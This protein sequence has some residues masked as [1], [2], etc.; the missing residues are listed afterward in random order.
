MPISEINRKIEVY[1]KG[2]IC[3]GDKTT[4]GGQVLSGSGKM[5]FAGIGVARLNDPVSCP[6]HGNTFII[7]AHPSF[8]DNGIPVAFHGHH[9]G[10]GCTLISSQKGATVIAIR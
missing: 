8:K 7:E 4:H 3:I 6:Q 9:C 5:K 2:V 1:M 10:C